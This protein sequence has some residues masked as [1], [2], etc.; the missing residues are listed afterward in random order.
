[1]KK[2]SFLLFFLPLIA[3]AQPAKFSL[4]L[5]ELQQNPEIRKQAIVGLSNRVDW[6]AL[7]QK[8]KTEKTPVKQ[9]AV[10]VNSVLKQTATNQ[11]SEILNFINTYNL[12][13][14]TQIEVLKAWYISNALWVEADYEGLIALSH[15]GA[16]DYITS[17]NEVTLNY[18]PPVEKS[19]TSSR[20]VGGSE[21]GLKAIKAPFL[22]QMGYTG[23]GAVGYIIDTG[24][25]PVHPAIRENFMGNFAPLLH[26]WKYYDLPFPGDKSDAHGTHVTGTVMGLDPETADTIGVAFG[27][28]YIA[29][30][31]IV[32]DL[33]M[34]KGVPALMTAFEWALNPDGDMN[35]SDDIPHV[36]NNSWGI[37]VSNDTTFC[38]TDFVRDIFM[39]C[40]AAGIAVVYSAGNSGPNP[41]TISRPQY[42]AI[43]PVLPFTVGALNGNQSTFPIA[44]FSS[45]GPIACNVVDSL[46]IKPEV[47]APGVDVRSSVQKNEYAVYSGTSMAGPHVA[48]AVL[49][50]KEVFPQASGK[51]LL[52]ALYHS[53]DDL[54][55]V[56]EDN[57]YGTGIINLQKAYDT[58]I[59]QFDA[60]APA[61]FASDVAVTKVE[62]VE[63]TCAEQ[64]SIVTEIKNT[65]IE[66][67][68]QLTLTYGKNTNDILGT[69]ASDIIIGPGE[70]IQFTIDNIPLNEGLN[71]IW[72]KVND[73]NQFDENPL[74][75]K[76]YTHPY[77]HKIATIP[78]L[79]TFEANYIRNNNI[80]IDNPDGKR[81]WDT[82][83]TNG[84]P[85]FNKFSARVRHRGYSP[86]AR[87]KDFMLLPEINFQSG[88]DSLF[89]EFYYAYT[90]NSNNFA[91]TLAVE[92]STDCGNSWINLFFRGGKQLETLDT[93]I[94]NFIPRK[95]HHWKVEKI[96]LNAL[97][98]QSDALFRFVT[99]NKGG[100]SI[101]VDNVAIYRGDNVLLQTE[102][103]IDESVGLYPNPANESVRIQADVLLNQ[104]TV[105]DATGRIMI[106]KPCQSDFEVLNIE[107]WNKGIYFFRIQTK[108]NRTIVKKLIKL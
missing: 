40:E 48:G 27:A 74:N 86:N 7:E 78:Y 17:T 35:T 96:H 95:S 97:Q 92:Y 85:T 89:L 75:D 13:A 70:T 36:I 71:D 45:R 50:L 28:R 72:V 62:S 3:F 64:V 91:D 14:S 49:L 59:T 94:V 101:F 23:H 31:P 80:L 99:I 51:D 82:V 102:K 18:E 57:T 84:L 39:A 4:S 83:S 44:S 104:I 42:V 9:R 61:N 38:N 65:G 22:W 33:S 87:Q 54:G 58:L 76:R 105:S 5:H 8:F 21:N 69:H 67:L 100:N 108:S 34:V 56:G 15:L 68:Q 60:A 41:G 53:A 88:N 37:A 32:E 106:N 11:Q 10:E 29:T 2:I 77:K 79:E 46:K 103:E 98:N 66:V 6:S 47:S 90:F 52:L 43:N 30:D 93:N 63:Q 73:P 55:S 81:T 12:T 20:S 107:H 26:T 24:V 25:W 1:M 19:A 16:V